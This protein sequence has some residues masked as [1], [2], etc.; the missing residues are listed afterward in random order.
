MPYP[1]V[2]GSASFTLGPAQNRFTGATRTDAETA[3]DNY[4]AA[5]PAWLAEYNADTTLNIVLEYSDNGDQFAVYQVRNEAGDAWLDNSSAIGVKGD[6]GSSGV[7]D[8]EPGQVGQKSSTSDQLV[9]AGATVD[10]TTGMW[11]FDSAIEVPSGSLFVSDALSIS[12]ATY[13]LFVNEKITGQNAVGIQS[14]ID[15]T[16]SFQPFINAAGDQFTSVAQGDFSTTITTNPIVLPL[17]SSSN[18]QTN[19]FRLKVASPMTNF[20]MSLVDDASGV[21]LKYI[22]SKRAVE[23][24]EGG[25]TLPAGDI[26]INLNSEDPDTADTF[27][28]GFTPLRSIEARSTTLTIEADSMALLGNSI[29]VPYVE[30]ELQKL[31][32]INIPYISDV[33]NIADNYVRLNDQY[34]TESGTTGGLVVNYEATST[35]DTVT[36]QLFNEGVD[37]SAN[38]FVITD[39]SDTFATSDLIQITGT[40]LN[41]G[42]YE[43]LSHTGTT[44]T[45]RG[46]GLTDTVEDFT[47]SQWLE[48]I[49]SASIT[50][51]NVNVLRSSSAG[52]WQSGAG[53]VTP[54]TF[55]NIGGGGSGD[56][57]GPN[58]SLQNVVAYFTDL[59]GK[60]IADYKY[61]EL[62]T[63]RTGADIRFSTDSATTPP[64]FG[65]D[66]QTTTLQGQVI[67]DIQNQEFRVE[68]SNWDLALD[69]ALNTVIN[70]QVYV[71]NAGRLNI[72]SPDAGTSSLIDFLNNSVLEGWVGYNATLGTTVLNG[73]S[74]LLLNHSGTATIEKDNSGTDPILALNDSGN[75]APLTQIYIDTATPEGVRTAQ[76]GALSIVIDT[77]TPSNDGIYQLHSTVS[78]NTPWVKIGGADAGGDVTGPSSSTTDAITKFSDTTGK[79]ID[80]QSNITVANNGF[81]MTPDGTTPIGFSIDSGAAS[82]IYTPLTGGVALQTGNTDVAVQATLGGNA[83]LSGTNVSIGAGTLTTLSTNGTDATWN[84]EQFVL[85]QPD[86]NADLGYYLKDNASADLVGLYW[87]DSAARAHLDVTGNTDISS[88]VQLNISGQAECSLTAGLSLNIEAGNGLFLGNTDTVNDDSVYNM[89]SAGPN[90][91]RADVYLSDTSPEGVITAQLGRSFC[92]VRG[93]TSSDDDGLWYLNTDTASQNTPWVQIASMQ[94]DVNDFMEYTGTTPVTNLGLMVFNGTSG[95]SVNQVSGI[96]ALNAQLIYTARNGSDVNGIRW[97]DTN[98]TTTLGTMFMN[99]GSNNLELDINSGS[100]DATAT[101]AYS[102]STNQA[103]TAGMLTLEQTGANGANTSIHVGARNPNGDFAGAAHGDLYFRANNNDFNSNVYIAD[104]LTTSGWTTLKNASTLCWGNLNVQSGT[105]TRYLDLWFNGQ[106]QAGSSDEASRFYVEKGGYLTNFRVTQIGDGNGNFVTYTLRLN[107]NLTTGIVSLAST[108]STAGQANVKIYVSRGDYVDVEVTKGSSVGSS[109]KE[110]KFACSFFED[111][112]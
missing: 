8:L 105:T 58:G 77:T 111:G 90:G 62:D 59:T 45:I 71:T 66:D 110:V 106:S 99:S 97:Y 54:I 87:D 27:N 79:A 7:D 13:E 2:G 50:K 95:T 96:S 109:P 65:F 3:R 64:L 23:T 4:A 14:I 47:K 81:T 51:V 85:T 94:H 18:I 44:L 91:T 98:G 75:S 67:L 69:S 92:F 29:G 42:L 83:S 107:G 72:D 26:E 20:R 55:T 76:P 63:A 43:V 22:P 25:L 24:G 73:E 57:T 28:I 100:I 41:N 78:A 32:T 35:K 108:A 56:V 1:T 17:L 40:K 104:E 60:N 46:V 16:G 53:S 70:G 15:D 82:L 52:V 88:S 12:E 36:S 48:V 31:F 89:V 33:S 61:L 5:N 112:N 102:F 11:T 93:A 49:D 21:V 19:I 84:G 39:G 34:I 6:T 10:Q 37:A 101:S 68:S 86:A 103:D 74:D 80:E 9:Y 30:N 38:P